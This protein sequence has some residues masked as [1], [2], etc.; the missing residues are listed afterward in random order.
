MNET[1]RGAVAGST[2]RI[3]AER[4]VRENLEDAKFQ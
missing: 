4:C 3:K 2:G 1:C